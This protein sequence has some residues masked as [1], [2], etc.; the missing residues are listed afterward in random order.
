MANEKSFKE[1]AIEFGKQT[2]RATRAIGGLVLGP[3][4]SLWGFG[5]GLFRWGNSFEEGK[6]YLWKRTRNLRTEAA[7]KSA[8]GDPTAPEFMVTGAV[9]FGRIGGI[10]LGTLA[11]LGL[12]GAIAAPFPGTTALYLG[13]VAAIAKFAGITIG[14]TAI[15]RT[16]GAFIGSCIDAIYYKTKTALGDAKIAEITIKST[17][18]YGLF[19]EGMSSAFAFLKKIGFPGFKDKSSSRSSVS[20]SDKKP[21]RIVDDH[22][23]DTVGI[24]KKVTKTG[25]PSP[26]SHV[27]A[28]APSHSGQSTTRP[29]SG[30]GS[31]NPSH[32]KKDDDDTESETPPTTPRNSF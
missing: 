20:S 25:K 7:I 26:S 29:V 13:S 1:R 15:G 10:L 4:D 16:V 2:L 23:H 12:I 30:V 3:V 5:K 9:A 21:K 22:S 6:P 8:K 14:W 32:K 27:S 18:G 19:G 24:S 11:I 28:E 31:V 17:I